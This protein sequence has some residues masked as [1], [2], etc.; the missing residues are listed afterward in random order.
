MRATGP[1]SELPVHDRKDLQLVL[2]VDDVDQ[3]DL[4]AAT[5][6]LGDVDE[7]E[8]QAAEAVGSVHE[9]PLDAGGTGA[10]VVHGVTGLRV[11]GSVTEE[12]SAAL[13]RVLTEIE[14]AKQLGANALVRARA[15]FGWDIVA[16]K[17]K[18]LALSPAD[19]L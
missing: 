17:T 18:R 12:V 19:K 11:N 8:L 16:E 10:A 3:A 6:R 9:T 1:L 7:A 2:V 4:Q 13:A 5:H 14:F 15:E